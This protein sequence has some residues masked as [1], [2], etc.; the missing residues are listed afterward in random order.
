[1]AKQEQQIKHI[2]MLSREY[3]NLAG[4]GGVKDVAC[5]LAESLARWTG[6]SVNVVLPSYGFLDPPALGFQPVTDPLC[7]D[8]L[9]RLQIAMHLPDAYV[10]EEVG[11][12]YQKINRVHVYLVD[13][14][15]FRQKSAVY[16]YTEDDEKVASWQQKAMGHHDYFAM[17][18]LHQKAALE[19]MV[20]LDAK[21]DIIHCHDGH[22][23]ILPALIREKSGY[24]SYFRA[25]GFLVTIHNAG[26]GYH[27]EVADIPY[28]TSITDLPNQIINAN[29]LDGKFDPFLVAGGYAVLNT[30]SE[31]YARELQETANDRLTGWLGHE[32]KRRNIILEGVTNGIDP[33]AFSSA[34]IAGDNRE[35]LFD[36]G[37]PHDT[38]SGK[39]CCKAALLAEIAGGGAIPGIHRYGTLQNSVEYP[40]FTFIGRLSEQKGID[41]LLEVMEVFLEKNAHCQLL[42]LGNGDSSFE[43]RLIALTESGRLQGRMCFLQGFSP[44]LANR[45]FAAGDF[46]VIP[47]KYEPC[48]LTDFIA[49]LF[50]NI[51]VVHHVGGLVKV[52]DKVTG[53]AYRGDAPDDLL[54]ALERA[55]ILYDDLAAK[56]TMQLQAIQEIE[57]KYTWTNVMQK[58][59]ELYREARRRQICR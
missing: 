21:P 24:H 26:I 3:G 6:R 41:V 7:P 54:E 45:V 38:L 8:R 50:G 35:M 18:L 1:M 10:L 30:V 4:A 32:L 37:A 58:Y 48:G 47:S 23:A 17:N 15:R 12:Y 46:F 39:L 43:S 28:A 20:C 29:L 27:Q 57:Q 31:N 5:Q 25:T 2:W 52:R 16:T 34:V 55:L 36:P 51:P 9:F 53:I 22:T 33:A 56:R 40:L 44:H 42:V 59:L 19:L 13:A 49:Q 11:Y 14:E